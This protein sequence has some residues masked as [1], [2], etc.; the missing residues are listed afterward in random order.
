[1]AGMLDEHAQQVEHLG[2][3]RY[4]LA[5]PQQPMLRHLQREAIEFVD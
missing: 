3:E 4:D 5:V 1:M 2:R